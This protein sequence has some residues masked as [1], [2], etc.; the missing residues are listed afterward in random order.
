MTAKQRKDD[1]QQLAGTHPEARYT[2]QVGNEL[3]LM[4][5]AIL[6]MTRGTGRLTLISDEHREELATTARQLYSAATRMEQI[7]VAIDRAAR[8]ASAHRARE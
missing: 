2:E 6:N 3:A 4:G 5:A 1:G 7:A 8:D